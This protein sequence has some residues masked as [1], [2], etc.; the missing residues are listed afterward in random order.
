MDLSIDITP[1][2]NEAFE[3][4]NKKHGKWAIFKANEK[5]DA[6]VL[7]CEGGLESTFDNFRDAIPESEP[8]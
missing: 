7:D 8:R 4:V 3:K 1:E 2:V 6:V 5:R